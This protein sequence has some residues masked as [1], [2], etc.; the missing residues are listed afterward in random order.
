M[1]YFLQAVLILL[2]IFV[3]ECQGWNWFLVLLPLGLQVSFMVVMMSLVFAAGLLQ[4]W[5]GKR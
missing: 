3:P 5:V 1:I 4:A 2:K